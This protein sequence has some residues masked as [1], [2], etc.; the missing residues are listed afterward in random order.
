MQV[1]TM[2]GCGS[3]LEVWTR[4]SSFCQCPATSVDGSA[5]LSACHESACIG[6]LDAAGREL[7]LQPTNRVGKSHTPRNL[8]CLLIAP[9]EDNPKVD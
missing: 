9:I 4:K 5:T 6:S 2:D 3:R 8:K 7:L 1:N